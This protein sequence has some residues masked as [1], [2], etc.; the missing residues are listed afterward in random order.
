MIHGLLEQLDSLGFFRFVQPSQVDAVKRR[1]VK[2][3]YL[4][5]W[6]QQVKRDYP[7]D[8]KWLLKGGVGKFLRELKPAF[9]ATGVDLHPI[10]E[11]CGKEGY[12]IKVH[13]IKYVLYSAE[14]LQAASE[15]QSS[16][17]WDNTIQR[18]FAL[19]NHWLQKAGSDERIFSLGGA[20]DHWA[21]IWTEAIH[22]L[23]RK[24]ILWE[25]TLN[26]LILYE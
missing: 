14:E 23:L 13:G 22:T 15:S 6:T 3:P 8:G 16:V 2:N 25:P 19:I 20:N 5:V 10:E 26:S 18:S 21:Y 4:F 12:W 9:K 7:A 24:S 11:Q 1:L 17:I